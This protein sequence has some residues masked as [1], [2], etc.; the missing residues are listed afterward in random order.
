MKDDLRK[1]YKLLRKNITSEEK[2]FFDLSIFNRLTS[3]FN[4]TEKNISIFLPIEKLK[5]IIEYDSLFMK[6][7][8]FLDYSILLA[9]ERT[10]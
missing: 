3:Q 1:Q 4:L 9:V 10:K 6:K 5:E 8:N 7:C 2:I